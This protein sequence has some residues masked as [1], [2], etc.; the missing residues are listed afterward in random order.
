MGP[1][2]QTPPIRA[3]KLT[4]R[5]GHEAWLRAPLLAAA[6]AAV[7]VVAV[8]ASTAASIVAIWI[9]SETFAHGF[10]VIPLCLWLVW[11]QR[12]A[13]ALQT[14][15]P[16]WP[17]LLVVLAAGAMWLVMSTANVLGLTQFA[18]AFMIQAAVVTVVGL[19]VARVLVFPLVFLLFAVPFGEIFIPALIDWT[20][21]FTVAA[22]RMSGVPVF[23]EANHFSIPSGNWSVVEA[24][25]GIRYIIASVMVGVI[26]SAVA[27]RSTRRRVLFLL[28]SFVTPVVA[29]WLR[30]YMIVM[31]GH[32]SGNRIAVGVDHLIYGWVFF[33]LVMLLL[34]WIGSFWQEAPQAL[35]LA[36]QEPARSA[37][38]G[39]RAS[40][41]RLFMAATACV[42]AAGL[43]VPIDAGLQRQV[44]SSAPNV[45]AVL[46]AGGWTPSTAPATPWKPHYRGQ[47]WDL[48]QEFERDGRIA[49]LYV[50]YYRGQ[51]KGRELVTSGNQLITMEDMRWK[52]H[53]RLSDAVDWSGRTVDAPRARIAGAAETLDVIPLLWVAGRV[54]SSEYVAKALLA[55]SKLT[56][57]GDDAA[58]I[59][60]YASSGS[61]GPDPAATLR[62]FA[63][64]MTPGIARALDAV[65]AGGRS[66]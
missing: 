57:A 15:A 1:A 53:E 42:V 20:A 35:P 40:R 9:R 24:C 26:Y 30:A 60:F 14:A 7:G 62:E 25:S 3:D 47:A 37:G 2:L 22:L 64:A 12:Q 39:A 29:N 54:T 18:L 65:R 58:L 56:G 55:W 21:D 49:G 59:V 27:Y 32:L 28:A 19:P 44:P 10:L 45:A 48:Q 38:S 66:Q 34:F 33:G 36:A 46:P 16:W 11:R 51:S 31:L 61:G 52:R 13:L 50:A 63:Q 8:H 4:Q 17:G 6:L 5:S 41:V 43:W 23:R